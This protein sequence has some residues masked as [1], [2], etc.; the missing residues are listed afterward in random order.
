MHFWRYWLSAVTQAASSN[1]GTITPPCK[2]AVR[3]PPKVGSRTT[4]NL[5]WL[6]TSQTSYTSLFSLLSAVKCLSFLKSG[7]LPTGNCCQFVFPES[8]WPHS[9]CSQMVWQGEFLIYS[10]SYLNR[11]YVGMLICSICNI[12]RDAVASDFTFMMTSVHS[13]ESQAVTGDWPLPATFRQSLSTFVPQHFRITPL[14]G[15]VDQWCSDLSGYPPPEMQWSPPFVTASSVRLKRPH[16]YVV[17][18][19]GR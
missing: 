4:L 10:N 1:V 15:T 6:L 9:S 18:C 13:V 16:N 7:V 5:W 2:L 3:P 12:S 17:S 19:Q 8:D 11:I 14:S